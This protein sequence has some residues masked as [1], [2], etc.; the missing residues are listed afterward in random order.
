MIISA[1]ESKCGMYFPKIKSNLRNIQSGVDY[2]GR[3]R[4]FKIDKVVR[5][6]GQCGEEKAV[7]VV[8]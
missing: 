8:K 4:D 6:C 5:K 2:K 1:W 3:E 7:K